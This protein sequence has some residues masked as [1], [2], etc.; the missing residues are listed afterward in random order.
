MSE[1]E[2]GKRA[3]YAVYERTE[4]TLTVRTRQTTHKRATSSPGWPGVPSSTPGAAGSGPPGQR[5]TSMGDPLRHC[6]RIALKCPSHI[7]HTQLFHAH[8]PP[9]AA[10]STRCPA[11][12]GI[13]FFAISDRASCTSLP[14]S[15]SP[16][17]GCAR[18]ARWCIG[19][20][21]RSG[22]TQRD[23]AQ[24]RPSSQR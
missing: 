4:Q 14:R 13:S 16:S 23:S 3:Q 18:A 15:R 2:H 10:E 6:A 5:A 12:S 17:T 22:R 24:T 20:P 9:S 21:G 1:F 11:E 7:A 8:R 19:E